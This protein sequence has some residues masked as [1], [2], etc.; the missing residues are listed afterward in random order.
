MKEKNPKGTGDTVKILRG[1]NYTPER[2]AEFLLSSAVDEKDY[3]KTREEVR[4]M[5]LDPDKISHRKPK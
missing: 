1:E 5:G 2:R 4:K 3:L